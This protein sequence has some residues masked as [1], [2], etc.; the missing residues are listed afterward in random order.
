M[1][2][3]ITLFFHIRNNFPALE[4]W[5]VDIAFPR[6]VAVLPFPAL[7]YYTKLCDFLAFLPILTFDWELIGLLRSR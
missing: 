6:L 4:S 1:F 7:F 3:R 5:Q 2:S